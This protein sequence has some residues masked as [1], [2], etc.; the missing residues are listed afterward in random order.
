MTVFLNQNLLKKKIHIEFM[1]YRAFKDKILRKFLV[2][3]D[4]KQC[5]QKV[6]IYFHI[7]CY[8]SGVS[9]ASSDFWWR[10][11]VTP[12][13]K[14]TRYKETKPFYFYKYIVKKHTMLFPACFFTFCLSQLKC[15]YA[16]NHRRLSSWITSKIFDSQIFI[17]LLHNIQ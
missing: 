4:T 6:F 1:R 5:S 14:H 17:F 16:E 8:A 3:R 15:P 2:Y 9:S 13:T 12:E 10:A 11:D 7:L